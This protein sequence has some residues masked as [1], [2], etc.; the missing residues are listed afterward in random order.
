MKSS[1][2]FGIFMAMLSFHSAQADILG[3][4]RCEL[5]SAPA[6]AA[7]WQSQ[8]FPLITTSDGYEAAESVGSSRIFELTPIDPADLA[9]WPN[10]GG[11]YYRGSNDMWV[12]ITP[13]DAS[14][15]PGTAFKVIKPLETDPN[16][17]SRPATYIC[18]KAM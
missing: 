14:L 3:A 16:T 4:S 2:S 17:N 15:P 8:A 18:H 13:S 11:R 5:A 12:I 7:E 9:G 6:N 10:Y 1:L